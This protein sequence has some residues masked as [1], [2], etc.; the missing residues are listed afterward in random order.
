VRDPSASRI[1]VPISEAIDFMSDSTMPCV[2]TAGL[3]TRMPEAIDAGCG[4]KGMA[5]LLSTM[6]A[7]SQRDSASLPVTTAPDPSV[8][9]CRSS[10]ARWVSVPPA[11]GR[12]PSAARPSVSACALATTR[13]A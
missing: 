5:F 6:P 12:S 3:P 13:R 7:A 2:V 8:T 1:A 9:C 11:T 10:S 4:S